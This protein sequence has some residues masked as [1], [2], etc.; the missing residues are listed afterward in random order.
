MSN[1]TEHFKTVDYH[2]RPTVHDYESQYQRGWI[3]YVQPFAKEVNQLLGGT[4]TV[5]ETTFTR[6]KRKRLFGL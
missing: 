1:S 3:L 2:E 6:M 5:W 4:R